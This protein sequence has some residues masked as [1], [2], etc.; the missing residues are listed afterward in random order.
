MSLKEEDRKIIIELE[1]ERVDKTL[2]GYNNFER[3]A[4]TIAPSMS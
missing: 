1:L 4:I 3:M 2:Y